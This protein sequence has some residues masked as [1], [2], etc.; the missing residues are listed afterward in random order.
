MCLPLWSKIFIVL[1]LHRDMASSP[2]LIQIGRTDRCLF[3]LSKLPQSW[4]STLLSRSRCDLDPVG[5]LL[6][7][8]A[9]SPGAT[10]ESFMQRTVDS[11]GVG[12]GVVSSSTDKGGSGELENQEL[13]LT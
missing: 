6:G 2:P 10:T 12:V 8:G 7:E 5:G 4:P 9:T 3:F 11:H 13:G 1:F